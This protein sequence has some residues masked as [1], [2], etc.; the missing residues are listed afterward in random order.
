MVIMARAPKAVSRKHLGQSS[1][2]AVRWVVERMSC[3]A[4]LFS[5]GPV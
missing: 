3:I 1:Q 4:A 5:S 2:G